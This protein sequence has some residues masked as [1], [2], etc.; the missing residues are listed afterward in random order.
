MP[1]EEIS[2]K[3]NIKNYKVFFAENSGF[4]DELLEMPDT[5]FII[6]NKVWELYGNELLEDIAGKDHIVLPINEENKTIKTAEFIYGQIIGRSAKKN[7]NIISIGGGITQDVTGF[8]ASTLYRGVNWIFVPT[9]LL[10]QAD[11]CIGAKTSLNFKHFKNLI[12]TF[13]PPAK[14]YIYTPFLKTQSQVDYF[15]GV[16]EIAKLHLMGGRKFSNDLISSTEAINKKDEKFLLKIIK[17]SLLIKKSYIEEDEFDKGHRNLLNFGHCFGH[18]IEAAT[19]FEVPH[20]QAVVLGIILAGR[21]ALSRGLLKEADEK[22]IRENI[23]L[24]FLKIKI[25]EIKFDLD[26]TVEAFSRDKKRVGSNLPLVMMIDDFKMIIVNDLTVSEARR[27]LN[28]IK[29]I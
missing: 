1:L 6:D 26:K 9:T 8:A 13:F 28:Y 10:A 7:I 20:G 18:A 11:S 2:L 25:N 19:D 4:L 15:S 21:V 12:G 5:F 24:P 17:N 29:D 16:G 27:T 22:F 23:L 3:S 14:I